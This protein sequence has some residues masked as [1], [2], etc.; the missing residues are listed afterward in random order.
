M[1]R[2]FKDKS[3]ESMNKKKEK[4]KLLLKISNQKVFQLM[5]INQSTDETIFSIDIG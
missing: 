4:F 1:N 2:I 5:L 3:I